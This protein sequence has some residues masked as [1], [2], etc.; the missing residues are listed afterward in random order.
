MLFFNLIP[1]VHCCLL[2]FSAPALVRQIVKQHL[3]YIPQLKYRYVRGK[4]TCSI[5]QLQNT[6]SALKQCM[7]ENC[8][9]FQWYPSEI[10]I[11]ISTSQYMGCCR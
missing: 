8:A 6:Q 9:S 3:Q 5:S 10:A 4:M 2:Q 11:I 7:Y 1:E